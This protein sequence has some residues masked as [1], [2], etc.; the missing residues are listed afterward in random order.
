[1][2]NVSIG[3]LAAGAMLYLVAIVYSIKRKVLVPLGESD[4]VGAPLFGASWMVTWIGGLHYGYVSGDEPMSMT[5]LL[6]ASF[7]AIIGVALTT[8][9]RCYYRRR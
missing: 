7:L 3:L 4:S 5:I 8:V 6:V 2:L 9:Y 1:M